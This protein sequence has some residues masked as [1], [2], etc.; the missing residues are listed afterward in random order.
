MA[1]AS[2]ANSC[3]SGLR[4][5]CSVGGFI[6][7]TA[8]QAS[9]GGLFGAATGGAGWGIGA[10]ASKVGSS[11]AGASAGGV[12]STNPGIMSRITSKLQSLN[13]LKKGCSF[14]PETS[15]S[16]PSGQRAIS[17]L[18]VG[19]K[20]YAADPA[21]GIKS[22]RTVTAI[23]VHTDPAIEYLALDTG[24]V[25]TTPNHP[26]YTTDQGWVEAGDLAPGDLIATQSGSP[27]KVLWLRVDQEPTAMWD[28]TVDGVHTFFVGPG[29]ALVHNCTLPGANSTAVIGRQ[30]DTSVAKDWAGHEVLDLPMNQWSIQANDSWV[31]S[32]IGRRMQ[33]YVASPPRWGNLWASGA[34]RPTVFGRELRQFLEAGYNWRGY[35]LIP[36]GV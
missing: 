16:T 8:T 32:V 5:D 6:F 7:E 3:V 15:V 21:T 26:F 35:T 27:A 1:A 33:V 30:A 23:M 17:T 22:A 24:M 28:L 12:T 18:R 14:T 31:Q 13:P 34:G 20:V 4:Q 9:V 25:V 29:R 10:V 11:I 36:P 19:D 2:Y